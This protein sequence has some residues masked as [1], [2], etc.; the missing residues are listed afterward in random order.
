MQPY[1]VLQLERDETHSLSAEGT[2][3]TAVFTSQPLGHQQLVLLVK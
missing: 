3:V 2:G 1:C